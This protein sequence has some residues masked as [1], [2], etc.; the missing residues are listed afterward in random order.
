MSSGAR[1]KTKHQQSNTC[2]FKHRMSNQNT[3][4]LGIWR[5]RAPKAQEPVGNLTTNYAPIRLRLFG[6]LFIIYV[7]C[8]PI[9]I[10]NVK[11]TN[12]KLIC[13]ITYVYIVLA[14]RFDLDYI[15]HVR[16]DTS[17]VP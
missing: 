9:C 1:A 11:Y 13:T 6:T 7:I 2:C 5:R 12:I 17:R 8:V 10:H 3:N 15:Q 4:K 14:K 16:Y